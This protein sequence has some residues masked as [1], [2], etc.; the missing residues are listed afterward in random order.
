M[1]WHLP[2]A[3]LN[4][5]CT[6]FTNSVTIFNVFVRHFN[7][8]LRYCFA[9]NVL[10]II[11]IDWWW[12]V[13]NL[14][15]LS[16]GILGI[17][18]ALFSIVWSLFVALTSDF[19]WLKPSLILRNSG[20]MSLFT[21]FILLCKLTAIATKS[22]LLSLFSDSPVRAAIAIVMWIV[23][24][25][26]KTKVNSWILKSS[27][28]LRL[29]L[30]H[31]CTHQRPICKKWNF[32]ENLRQCVTVTRGNARWSSFLQS[33]VQ[34]S[35]RSI[36]RYICI[37]V[38]CLNELFLFHNFSQDFVQK[39]TPKGLINACG[40]YLDKDSLI[41]FETLWQRSVD[42]VLYVVCIY[43]FLLCAFFL[44]LFLFLFVTVINFTKGLPE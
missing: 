13:R 36:V 27:F 19:I 18:P 26:L 5:S 11:F 12:D 40:F 24:W 32:S 28:Y 16:S 15:A 7:T 10:E 25:K 8:S 30:K 14:Q 2:F 20:T 42:T 22:G 29:K 21:E 43:Y 33:S 23:R 44:F 1:L 38:F 9:N 4:D 3:K 31:V 41:S 37:Y 6:S 17:W 35:S 39:R 34:F